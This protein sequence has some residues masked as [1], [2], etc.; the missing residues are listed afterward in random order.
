MLLS[1]PS[2][3]GVDAAGAFSRVQL[4]SQ[5]AA[6]KGVYEDWARFTL[7]V[8]LERAPET[9]RVKSADGMTVTGRRYRFQVSGRRHIVHYQA[10]C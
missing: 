6:G 10:S 8:D 9:V 5:R 3:Q 1:T 7:A 4:V 2:A